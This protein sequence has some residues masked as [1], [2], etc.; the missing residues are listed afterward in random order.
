[1]LVGAAWVGRI[2]RLGRP[3]LTASRLTDHDREDFELRPNGSSGRTNRLRFRKPLG[4]A[5]DNLQF[6][7]SP[8][9]FARRDEAHR[10]RAGHLQRPRRPAPVAIAL[11]EGE[12][13]KRFRHRAFRTQHDFDAN[14]GSRSFDDPRRRGT[15]T[16]RGW[17]SADAHLVVAEIGAS[18]PK[19]KNHA[20]CDGNGA[21]NR[22]ERSH[23]MSEGSHDRSL[24]LFARP[25]G[26]KARDEFLLETFSL[27]V[28]ETP[29]GLTA[30]V[31]H[32][33]AKRGKSVGGFWRRRHDEGFSTFNR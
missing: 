29:C 22:A 6:T 21:P 10:S 5:D 27:F 8:E 24:R 32:S 33:I 14:V 26:S 19:Q 12:R 9:R 23:P 1:M 28:R 17:R 18:L 20:R 25:R 13:R 4:R 30:V 3:G 7:G 11:N 16:R 31:V 15:R 2:S